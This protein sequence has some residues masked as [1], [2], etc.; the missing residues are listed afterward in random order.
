M[1]MT[2][3]NVDRTA[4]SLVDTAVPSNGIAAHTASRTTRNA[5]RLR[6]RS[7]VSRL[8]HGGHVWIERCERERCVREEVD[9]VEQSRSRRLFAG[10]EVCV[11]DVTGE[12]EQKRHQEQAQRPIATFGGYEQVGDQGDHAGV[13]GRIG[14]VRHRCQH[15]HVAVEERRD[16]QD[17][18]QEEGSERDQG[19]IDERG[20]VVA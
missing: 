1:R 14:T 13:D 18:G 3:S 4:I 15:S 12:D 16:E 10:K 19:R 2:E 20:D 6:L 8:R 7:E 17:P 9:A 5:M 11:R